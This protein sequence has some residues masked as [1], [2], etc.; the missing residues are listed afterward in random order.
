MIIPDLTQ[1]IDITDVIEG[2]E[3][4]ISRL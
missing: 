1:S 3:Q 4:E 2:V